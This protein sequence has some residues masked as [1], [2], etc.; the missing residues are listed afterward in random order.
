VF[1]DNCDADLE[2]VRINPPQLD[3]VGELVDAEEP[4]E[5]ELLWDLSDSPQSSAS[6]SL[7]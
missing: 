3:W 7:A 5:E 1:C 4:Q 2:I 6:A